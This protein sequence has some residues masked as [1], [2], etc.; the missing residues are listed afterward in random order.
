MVPHFNNTT[1]L[2]KACGRIGAT[3][4]QYYPTDESVWADWLSGPEPNSHA[5]RRTA[6]RRFHAYE[7]QY[8]SVDAVAGSGRYTGYHPLLLIQW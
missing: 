8:T 1:P 7:A 5:H 3:F 4:Y 6:Q 2:T